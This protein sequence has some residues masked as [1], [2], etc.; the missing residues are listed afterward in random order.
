MTW[1]RIHNHCYV[2]SEHGTQTLPCIPFIRNASWETLTYRRQ[3]PSI[4]VELSPEYTTQESQSIQ[5][6]H[7]VG[8]DD[9]QCKLFTQGSDT[10]QSP[11]HSSK[12]WRKIKPTA[13]LRHSRRS[14]RLFI[15]WQD[16]RFWETNLLRRWWLQGFGYQR[17]T[18]CGDLQ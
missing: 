12:Q 5:K 8:I 13:H 2:C 7:L 11:R 16:G 17:N 14:I 1:N 9:C 3:T 10:E 18:H 6:I 15:V 4:T